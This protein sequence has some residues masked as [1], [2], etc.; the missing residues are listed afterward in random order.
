MQM[1]QEELGEIASIQ[2][3]QIVMQMV[4]ICTSLLGHVVKPDIAFVKP[5]GTPQMPRVMSSALNGD[6]MCLIVDQAACEQYCRVNLGAV[7]VTRSIKWRDRVEVDRSLVIVFLAQQ[8]LEYHETD[9]CR[10]F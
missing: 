2:S 4:Y 8:E 5:R 6:R 3:D 1:R 10:Q 7:G 9:L